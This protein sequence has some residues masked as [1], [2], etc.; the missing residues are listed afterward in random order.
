MQV[1]SIMT[2][3]P[4]CC[5]PDTDLQIVARAMVERDCGALPVVDGEQSRKPVGMITDRD[6]VCRLVADGRNPLDS[7]VRDAMSESAVTVRQ[8]AS[9]DECERLME[10]RQVRRI[11]VVDETGACCGIVAQ[12]DIALNAPAKE[13]AEVVKDI[14]QPSG[15]PS[16]VH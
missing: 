2:R 7:K 1:Q 13:T 16:N 11:P 4:A 12:A 6:I 9:L 15:P 8:D 5:T 3:D 14:S 10:E